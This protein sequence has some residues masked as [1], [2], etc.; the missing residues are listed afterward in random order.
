MV[1]LFSCFPVYSHV[2]CCCGC[3]GKAKQIK[4]VVVVTATVKVQSTL[5]SPLSEVRS[6]HGDL[7]HSAMGVGNFHF[8]VSYLGSEKYRWMVSTRFGFIFVTL[9]NLK[10]LE[11]DDELKL[12]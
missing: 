5:C 9:G 12:Q 8:T 10:S 3:D 7:H 1:I 11:I 4:F 6:W 2:L